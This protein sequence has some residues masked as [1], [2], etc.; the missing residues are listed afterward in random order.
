M[1]LDQRVEALEKQLDTLRRD[2]RTEF[3]AGAHEL[4]DDEK[5]MGPAGKVL[6]KHM[7]DHWFDTAARRL[8]LALIGLLLVGGASL[9][10]WAAGK[11]FA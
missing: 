7:G 4:R 3:K 2:I 8:L 1:N 9:V 5:F 11:G 10:L 6:A